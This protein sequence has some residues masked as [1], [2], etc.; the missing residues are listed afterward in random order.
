V[1]SRVREVVLFRHVEKREE[2]LGQS[3]GGMLDE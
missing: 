3:I 1:E 2:S